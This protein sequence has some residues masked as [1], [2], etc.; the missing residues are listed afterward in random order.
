MESDLPTGQ[1]T[2]SFRVFLFSDTYGEK[3]AQFSEYWMTLIVRWPHAKWHVK[4]IFN[5]LFPLGDFREP[6]SPQKNRKILEEICFCIDF[7][8]TQL[9]NDTVTNLY[10]AGP[11]SGIIPMIPLPVRA[12]PDEVRKRYP[13]LNL[14]STTPSINRSDIKILHH[15]KLGIAVVTVGSDETRYIYKTTSAPFA[16][17]DE[18][19][20]DPQL[21]LRNLER[22]QGGEG[23]VRLIATVFC[24]NPYHTTF[25]TPETGK[26]KLL[27][28]ILL[29][30]HPNGTLL[31]AYLMPDTHMKD[32][33]LVWGLQIA[34]AVAHIHAK[35]LTHLNLTLSNIVISAEWNAVLI[36][37]GG[38]I[39]TEDHLLPELRLRDR[40][41]PIV[42]GPE[43]KLRSDIWALGI[44]LYELASSS[45]G[46]DKKLLAAASQDAMRRPWPPSIGD[47]INK[48]SRPAT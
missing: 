18:N 19:I 42:I 11:S 28:G 32:R 45:E 10:I 44:I 26:A 6:S 17:S 43:T 7:E 33:L 47:I 41:G 22:L 1:S 21:E 48:L 8:R 13:I 34:K 9:F 30:Y 37:F 29:E 39:M 40:S 2:D 14:S 35:G 15:L 31:D 36:D 24:Y 23:I 25:S 12:E 46:L 4:V 5:G 20:R 16:D 38:D 3:G 27:E